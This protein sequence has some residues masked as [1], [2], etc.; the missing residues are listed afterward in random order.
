MHGLGNQFVVFDARTEPLELSA[1]QARNVAA[2]EQCDQILTLLPSEHADAFMR[3]QNADG[4]EVEACGNGARCAARLVM[5][6]SHTD[7]MVLETSA[8]LLRCTRAGS[9]GQVSVDMGI[10]R[11]DWQSIP[12]TREMNTR[13]GNFTCGSLT[14]PAFVN[15]G[16]PHAVLFVDD[17]EAIDLETIGPVIETDDLFPERINVE[18]V[19]TLPDGNLRMRVWERGVGITSACGSGAC[20]ALVA[21]ARR[22]KSRREAT[23][24]LDGGPLHILWNKDDRVIMT[25]ETAETGRGRMA[26]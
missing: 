26:L 13:G 11:F 20:A 3:I 14:R 8:E 6:E 7:A 12:L 21:A 9:N 25:G 24:V 2:I 18:V 17:A 19:S 16:N 4:S 10:P 5:D 23:V 22:G 15:I 1:D